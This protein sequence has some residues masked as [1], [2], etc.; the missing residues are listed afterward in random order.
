ME[1][2]LDDAIR[3]CREMEELLKPIGYHCGLTGSTLY[4]GRSEKDVDIIVY[5]HQISQQIATVIILET[6][7]VFTRS[8]Q[9][10]ASCKDKMIAVC[11]YKGMRVDLF[12]LK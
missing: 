9:D 6:L 4:K 10:E 3:I 8:V 5:P 1:I 7:G 11:E 2:T 12:F